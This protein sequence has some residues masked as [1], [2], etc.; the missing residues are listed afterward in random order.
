MQRLLDR[1]SYRD[2]LLLHFALGKAH[3]DAGDPDQAFAH[4]HEGNRLKRAAI[5]YD[6]NAAARL[7][8]TIARRD[9]GP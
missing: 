5:D 2:R 1:C 7:F 3:M 9:S 4:W 8:A 6:P